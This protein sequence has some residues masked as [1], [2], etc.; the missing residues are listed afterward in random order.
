MPGKPLQSKLSPHEDEIFALLDAGRNFRQVAEQMNRFHGLGVTHNAVFSFA[1]SRRKRRG[2]R[3]FFE[4]LSPDIRDQLLKQVAAVCLDARLHRHR[5]QHADSGRYGQGAGT[6]ADHQRQKPARASGGLR[7]R[8][9]DRP[10]LPDAP[11]AG[12]HRRGLVRPAPRRDA[13]F[14]SRP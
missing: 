7:A 5:G 1:K 12:R 8:P 9:R 6:G 4:G 14:G 13:A 2:A 10:G 11:P 3:L